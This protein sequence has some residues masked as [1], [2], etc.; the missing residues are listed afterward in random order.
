MRRIAAAGNEL[1]AP[2]AVEQAEVGDILQRVLQV[3]RGRGVVDALELVGSLKRETTANRNGARLIDRH[4]GNAAQ[5]RV[6]IGIEG[7]ALHHID[8]RAGHRVRVDRHA[9]LKG[10][11]G[12]T[13]VRRRDHLERAR[14]RHVDGLLRTVENDH[15][16][17]VR[18]VPALEKRK[19]VRIGQ[20]AQETVLAMR[21]GRRA[22]GRAGRLRDHLHARY[23]YMRPVVDHPARYDAGG[24]GQCR[25]T[26]SGKAK[27][28]EEQNALSYAAEADEQTVLPTATEKSALTGL[29]QLE[30]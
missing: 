11:A 1:H 9:A 30:C 3:G 7:L 20:D 16:D 10:A 23:R 25:R 28:A 26:R 14:E 8:L 18:G 4:A 29:F 6:L 19:R 13:G 17:R 24:L 2:D 15:R 21:V 5:Q 22:I 12:R 27:E